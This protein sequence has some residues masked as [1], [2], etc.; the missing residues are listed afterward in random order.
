MRHIGIFLAMALLIP[1]LASAQITIAADTILQ[2]CKLVTSFKTDRIII[3]SQEKYDET[4]FIDN[5]DQACV[6]F[7]EIDFDK[8]ILVGFKFRGSNCDRGIHWSAI[9][10]T[11]NGYRVQFAT[12]PNH[13]CRDL[14]YPI[15]WF[16]IDKPQGKADITFERVFIKE[17][18]R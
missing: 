7:G 9:V 12:G 1:T 14:Y 17:S 4:E 8:S 15:A 2:D 11:D 18:Y 5:F 16:I 10:E 6:P 13:I 3:D